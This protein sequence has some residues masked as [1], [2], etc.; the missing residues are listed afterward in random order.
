MIGREDTGTLS[1]NRMRALRVAFS[2]AETGFK[3]LGGKSYWFTVG[4]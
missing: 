4:G 1:T 2:K 3:K